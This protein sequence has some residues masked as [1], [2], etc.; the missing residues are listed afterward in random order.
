MANDEIEQAGGDAVCVRE[1]QQ[2]T[3]LDTVRHQHI[4]GRQAEQH[5]KREGEDRDTDVIRHDHA[6]RQRPGVRRNLSPELVVVDPLHDLRGHQRVRQVRV[7]ADGDE[8]DDRW[9][10]QQKRGGDQV[11]G[12]LAVGLWQRAFVEHRDPLSQVA[13]LSIH[14]GV[15]PGDQAVEIPRHRLSRPIASGSGEVRGRAAI[16][17]RQRQDLS[18]QQAADT[19]RPGPGQQ[20]LEPVPLGAPAGHKFIRAHLSMMRHRTHPALA[21]LS[22]HCDAI[23][24]SGR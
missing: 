13:A 19:A 22:Q 14:R 6:R 9:S 15:A 5:A 8:G 1:R 21:C 17:R 20:L 7:E 23:P 2:A 11:G 4:D 12:G 18:G 24:Q 3:Q 16:E 10:E